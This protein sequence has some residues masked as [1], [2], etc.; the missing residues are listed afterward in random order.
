MTQSI[1]VLGC[2]NNSKTIFSCKN[3]AQHSKG[4]LSNFEKGLHPVRVP[5]VP[6]RFVDKLKCEIRNKSLIF[7]FIKQCFFDFQITGHWTK[8]HFIFVQFSIISKK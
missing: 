4:F 7:V 2:K 5:K 3:L 8:F 6:F 1:Y